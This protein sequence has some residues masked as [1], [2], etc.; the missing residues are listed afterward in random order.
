MASVAVLPCTAC[1]RTAY[2]CTTQCLTMS[3][4]LKQQVEGMLDTLKTATAVKSN[5]AEE[6]LHKANEGFLQDEGGTQQLV[7]K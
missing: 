4:T 6:K 1:C 3:V 7:L 2:I 5:P